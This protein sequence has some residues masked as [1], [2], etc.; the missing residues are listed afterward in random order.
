MRDELIRLRCAPP[1]FALALTPFGGLLAEDIGESSNP[2]E[3]KSIQVFGDLCRSDTETID[4][5]PF[6]S[7]RFAPVRRLHLNELPRYGTW[8]FT[9]ETLNQEYPENTYVMGTG[10][11][12]IDLVSNLG[13][14][15]SDEELPRY[16]WH[17]ISVPSPRDVRVGFVAR[18]R[19]LF[20]REEGVWDRMQYS[21]LRKSEVDDDDGTL[22]VY[23]DKTLQEDVVLDITDAWKATFGEAMNRLV[24]EHF[25]S[26]YRTYTHTFVYQD[27]PQKA[28]DINMD[29]G[30][31]RNSSR[32]VQAPGAA[33]GFV[34]ND[35]GD[36]LASATLRIVPD[37]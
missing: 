5:S 9:Y 20:A 36:C 22:L 37:D 25:L 14:P 12:E 6:V 11:D 28:N 10:D 30:D 23:V 2:E 21:S 16:L 8:N 29:A 4:G 24:L 33:F 13:R 18:H 19:E 35:A 26:D 17:V 31:R 27:A 15:K 32:T 1:L 3:Q 7:V 34:L